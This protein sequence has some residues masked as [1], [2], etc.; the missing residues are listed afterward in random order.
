MPDPSALDDSDDGDDDVVSDR[1]TDQ[2]F[3]SNH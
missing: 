2:P 1:K 3:R